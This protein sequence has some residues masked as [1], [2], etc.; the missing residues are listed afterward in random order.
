MTCRKFR[1]ALS[2][3]EALELPSDAQLHVRG[4]APCARLLEQ[5]RALRSG[6]R[7]LS[8]RRAECVA[9]DRV[10]VALLR[11][12]REQAEASRGAAF[13]KTRTSSLA[14]FPLPVGI[15]S[16]GALTAAVAAF[17]VWSHLPTSR[18][19][20]NSP[21][22]SVSEADD[23]TLNGGFIPLPYFGSAGTLSAP[24]GDPDVVRVEVPR[25]TLVALGVPVA[26]EGSAEAVQAE[27][28]LGPGGMPQA[29]RVLE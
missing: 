13:A 7:S 16:A 19:F 6:L 4:C 27:L 8:A 25:S 23:S 1:S 9:P 24:A 18:P 3:L 29:V 22:V 5:E 2:A 20:G 12:F 17:L 15:L 10:E 14:F 21:A 11:E 28:L 26:D